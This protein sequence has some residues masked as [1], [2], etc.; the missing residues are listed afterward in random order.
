MISILSTYAR[1]NTTCG[2]LIDGFSGFLSLPHF[3]EHSDK[4]LRVWDLFHMCYPVAVPLTQ[5]EHIQD[6]VVALCP[7]A[8]LLLH[9]KF[10]SGK[11]SS[12]FCACSAL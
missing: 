4:D 3:L 5:Q 1:N 10:L 11:F 9:R 8:V 7:I 6:M 12:H 2:L